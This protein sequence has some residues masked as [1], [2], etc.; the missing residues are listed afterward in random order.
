[1]AYY[2]TYM[3][4]KNNAQSVVAGLT[5]HPGPL[6]THTELLSPS[7]PLSASLAPTA[8]NSKQYKPKRRCLLDL[9]LAHA[10]WLSQ[11]PWT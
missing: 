11:P 8:H 4:F 3:K 10:V 2:Q 5:D 9:T 6:D 7:V 1:M